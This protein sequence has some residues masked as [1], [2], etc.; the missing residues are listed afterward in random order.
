MGR[1]V[2]WIDIRS[3]SWW[4]ATTL[5]RFQAFSTWNACRKAME[6]CR[7]P[8]CLKYPQDF[9]K[10]FLHTFCAPGFGFLTALTWQVI[11]SR[12]S[13]HKAAKTQAY[14]LT[15]L[16]RWMVLGVSVGFEC[17]A[18]RCFLM[19]HV[20]FTTAFRCVWLWKTCWCGGGPKS[21]PITLPNSVVECDF[22][23]VFVENEVIDWGGPGVKR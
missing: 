8:T 22:Y 7:E 10:Y 13:E 19:S 18:T 17:L 15:D 14:K 4:W 3:W 16:D 12:G 21:F 11:A 5:G 20:R 2:F 1:N 6:N 23:W 9:L